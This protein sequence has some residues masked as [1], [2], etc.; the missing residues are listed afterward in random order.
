MTLTWT[1]HLQ[2]PGIDHD[3]VKPGN[4]CD[5]VVGQIGRIASMPCKTDLTILVEFPVDSG[6][7]HTLPLKQIAAFAP[8]RL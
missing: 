4:L 5:N 6:R 1:G 3:P 2:R 8:D 7:L